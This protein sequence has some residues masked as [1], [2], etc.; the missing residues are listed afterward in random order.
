[1]DGL[2]DLNN[3]LKILQRGLSAPIGFL[4]KRIIDIVL[5]L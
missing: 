3:E 2:A 5:A 1:M 4:P